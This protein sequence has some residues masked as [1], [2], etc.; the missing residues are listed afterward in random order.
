MDRETAALQTF[1]IPVFFD[2]LLIFGNKAFPLPII[3]II[4]IL[5][6]IILIRVQI[7]QFLLKVIPHGNGQIQGQFE[8]PDFFGLAVNDCGQGGNGFALLLDKTFQSL[9]FLAHFDAALCLAAATT[10]TATTE[11]LLHQT[12]DG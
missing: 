6:I 12:A 2:I 5:F 3:L 7:Q 8:G 1:G 10:T 9:I 4:L 11:S